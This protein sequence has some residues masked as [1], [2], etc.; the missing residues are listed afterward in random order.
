MTVERIG[1]V[2]AGLIGTS[3]GL[4]L[5]RN[6]HQARLADADE[7]RARAAAALGAGVAVT[8]D[9]LAACDHVVVCV[10]PSATAEVVG[11]VLSLALDATVSDVASS[12]ANVLAEVETLSAAMSSRFCGGHP[13]AGRERGG[14]GA[15]QPTLFD[16][17]TW[18][19]CPGTTTSE[20]ARTD[21]AELARRCGARVVSLDATAHDAVLAAV[22]HAPQLVAS[23][24]AARLVA[25][26][27]SAPT[28]AGP[29]FRDTTRLADSDPALWRSIAVAN[30]GPIAAELRAV[31]GV[32]VGTARSIE[33]GDGAAV[34][35]LVDAGRSARA[36]LPGKAATPRPAWARVG[37]VIADRPGE[38]ARLLTAAGDAGV[39]VEDLAIEHATDHP[40]G[41]VD[42][43]VRPEQADRL[44]AALTTGGWAA[45]R[46]D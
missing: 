45:H 25:A 8:W 26:G 32:L 20:R 19:V 9:E 42:I 41:Y 6:G 14:P 39:N 12:K 22:S 2:G 28:V 46:S 17:A 44:L 21:A 31:A 3:V 27:P 29:G 10:P 5:A 40:A 1:I 11:T 16:G 13:I 36:L 34:H 37:V 4:A 15:A 33:A 35:A 38:L 18:V 7:A 24:L 30:A 43:D 23:A